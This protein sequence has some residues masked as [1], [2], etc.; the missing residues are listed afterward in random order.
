M[1]LNEQYSGRPDPDTAT[2]A[3]PDPGAPRQPASRPGPRPAV[4]RLWTTAAWAGGAVVLFVLFL[5]ISLSTP[6]DSDGANNALQAWD[7]IHGNPLLH[8]WIIGDASAYTF[9]LPLYAIIEIFS[10]LTG[11]IFHVAGALTYLIV[12]AGAVALAGTG[13]R[14]AVKAARCGVAVA[15]L[16]APIITQQGASILVEAPDHIGT[17]AFL[18]FSFLLIDRAPGRRF[19][20]PLLAAIL[21]AGQVG[22]G[23]VLYVAVP[24]VLLVCLYHVLAARKIRTADTAIAVAAAASVPLTSGVR[25]VMLHFG[26]FSMVPPRTAISPVGQ[27]PGHLVVTWRA[28]R[29]IFGAF[30]ATVVPYSSPL[31][32]LAAVFGLACLLAAACGFAKVVWTWRTA[33]RAEQMLCVAIVVN[34]AAYMVSTL[35][36]TYSSREVAAVLPCGAVLAARACVPGH[37]LDAQHARL[38]AAAAGL[39]ALLPLTAAATLPPVTPP[40]VPLAAWLK[41]HG[42]RYG[43]AGYWDASA[44]TLQSHNQIQVRAV[45]STNDHVRWAGEPFGQIWGPGKV[46]AFYWETKPDWYH[47]SAHD[48]TFV[49][50]NG[51]Y[52]DSAPLTA[53]E[54]RR[55]FGNSAAVYQIAGRKIMI[56][57]TNILERLAAPFVPLALRSAQVSPRDRTI[58]SASSA[59]EAMSSPVT[60]IRTVSTAMRNGCTAMS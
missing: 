8:G 5:R 53:A 50:A 12:A 14:G 4:R 39:A 24:A 42:L 36:S 37:I 52:P 41:A 7:M 45:V 47:P 48:A 11:V 54:V 60:K 3:A 32:G 25:A 58:R 15:V 30:G 21:C 10:G 9:E 6:M 57:R 26:G 55:A 23:T 49:I 46:S 18:L 16:A 40:A 13:S 31:S 27:W 29:T 28:I 22:D 2:A 20:P 19:T 33:G 59:S 43:I 1:H 35:P 56:Y 34:L 17:S 38:A 51:Q 44:V